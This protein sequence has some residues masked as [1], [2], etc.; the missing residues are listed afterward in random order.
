MPVIPLTTAFLS[1][2]ASGGFGPCLTWEPIWCS[3]LPTGSEAVS[4]HMVRAATELLYMA[5][6]QQFDACQ[7]TSRPCRRTCNGV[8]AWPFS[9]GWWDLG[10]WP[11]PVL[12]DGNWYNIACGSCGGSC[13]CS[14]LDETYLPGPVVSV[15]QVKVDGVVLTKNVDYRLDDFRKLVRLGD[16]WPVCNDLNLPDTAAGTW[17]VTATYGNPVPDIGRLA[18]GELALQLIYNCL[19][20]DCCLIPGS[21]SQLTRQGVTI[22][23]VDSQTIF[24]TNRM[25]LML[26]DMFISKYNPDA[27]RGPSEVLAP[28]LYKPRRTG[29]G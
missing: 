23:F 7:I 14:R 13:S 24:E 3:A 2:G 16:I 19:G 25:G 4:G 9:G 15:D 12:F 20:M 11:R 18:V 17:S 27:L 22:D 29:T 28:E 5:T 26:C 10:S 6:G 1:P 21:V 8:E